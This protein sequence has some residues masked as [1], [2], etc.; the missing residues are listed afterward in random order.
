MSHYFFSYTEADNSVVVATDSGEHLNILRPRAE[1]ALI[2]TFNTSQE[3]HILSVSIVF[4]T[5]GVLIVVGLDLAKLSPHI[6]SPEKF[7]LHL[8]TF[9]VSKYA[10]IHKSFVKVEQLRW[11]RILVPEGESV[12]EH[13]HAFY[14]DGDDKRIVKVEVCISCRRYD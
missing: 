9:L 1:P 4:S 11:S 7:A 6:L 2:I 10:H 14:R 8:A 5:N 12:K 13:S 3:H